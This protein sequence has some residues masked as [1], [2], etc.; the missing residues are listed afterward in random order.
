MSTQI[1]SSI[2]SEDRHSLDILLENLRAP[3]LD[4]T[5]PVDENNVGYNAINVYVKPKKVS[6]D[7]QLG[8]PLND[9]TSL[10]E[11]LVATVSPEAT[12]GDYVPIMRTTQH[13]FEALKTLADKD[14]YEP[15]MTRN[16]TFSIAQGYADLQIHGT[17][18]RVHYTEDHSGM[19]N[20]ERIEIGDGSFIIFG[21]SVGPTEEPQPAVLDSGK[22]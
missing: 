22:T 12:R 5:V 17:R 10:A 1:P 9:A 3:Y 15:H 2:R 11:T 18:F 16:P 8:S 6:A 7:D 14:S 20:K 4:T 13:V 21:G 19:L